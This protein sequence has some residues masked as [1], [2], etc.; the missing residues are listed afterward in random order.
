VDLG[1]LA[2]QVGAP[3]LKSQV[4][5]VFQEIFIIQ[6]HMD[7]TGVTGFPGTREEKQ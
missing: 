7:F 3:L 5:R 1:H 6:S 2:A 4:E